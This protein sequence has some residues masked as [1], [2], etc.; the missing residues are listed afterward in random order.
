MD[1]KT[2]LHALVD[3]YDAL[4]IILVIECLALTAFS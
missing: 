3:K 4:I 1:L 2:R